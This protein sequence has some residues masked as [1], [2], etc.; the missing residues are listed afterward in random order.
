[1]ML[2]ITIAA[3]KVNRFESLILKQPFEKSSNFFLEYCF[4]DKTP[5]DH[6]TFYRVVV[7]RQLNLLVLGCKPFKMTTN[8]RLGCSRVHHV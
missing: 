1:M 6:G 8:L 7:L 3:K 2:F 4:S 5:R